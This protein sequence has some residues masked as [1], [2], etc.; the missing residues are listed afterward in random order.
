MEETR[1]RLR[2]ATL[3]FVHDGIF[4]NSNF[5]KQISNGSIGCFV[6]DFGEGVLGLDIDLHAFRHSFAVQF[7][8]CV[9]KISTLKQLLGHISIKSSEHS[10]K[11]TDSLTIEGFYDKYFKWLGSRYLEPVA[12]GVERSAPD[13]GR[14][15]FQLTE[16]IDIYLISLGFWAFSFW[17]VSVYFG[18]F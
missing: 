16:I 15:I 8:N 10:L 1:R 3:V 6:K 18:L 13:A 11:M 14:Y 12:Q 4:S 17:F 7:F 9:I 5:K 2:S